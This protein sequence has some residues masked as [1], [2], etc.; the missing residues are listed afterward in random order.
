M[1]TILF[2]LK[3]LKAFANTIWEIKFSI[4]QH[5]KENTGYR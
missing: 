5:C 4:Y 3:Q 2:S 1:A